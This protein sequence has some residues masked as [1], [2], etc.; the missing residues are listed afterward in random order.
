MKWQDGLAFLI[1]AGLA[2]FF[3]FP[4]GREAYQAAYAFSPALLS[5]LK[6]AFLA[7]AGEMLILRFKS[8]RYLSRQFGLLPKMLVWGLL[9][10]LIY[11]VFVIFSTGVPA[12]VF[13][14]A[15]PA[16]GPGKVASAFLISTFMNLIFA[17][18]MMLVHHLSDIFIAENGGRFPLGR[19]DVRELLAKADW[20]KMWG[21]VYKRTIPLFWIPAHTVT[22]LLSPQFRVLFAA[23]LSV[24]L[25]LFLALAARRS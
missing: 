7:T 20:K 21:F 1:F 5:F 12:L 14:G 16:G 6:F 19:L 11:C 2:A 18:P 4:A 10:L 3:V 13:G 23:L 9:G 15:A 25:G 17:P 8:G 22:F 24:V